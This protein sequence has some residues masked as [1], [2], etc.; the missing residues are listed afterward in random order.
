MSDIIKLISDINALL[1]KEVKTIADSIQT[2]NSKKAYLQKITIKSELFSERIPFPVNQKTVVPNKCKKPGIYVFVIAP[3][4]GKPIPIDESFNDTPDAPKLIKQN[5]YDPKTFTYHDLK[6]GQ[7]LY[8]GKAEDDLQKRVNEHIYGPQYDSTS[9]LKLSSK[10]RKKLLNQLVCVCFLLRDDLT[11]FV[12]IIL[13]SI[14]SR[15]H[16][17]LK[18]RVGSKRS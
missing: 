15:L 4:A 12:K 10:E 8:L 17:I 3:K 1:N 11:S 7:I 5:Y 6:N 9:A 2:Q 18:P 16:D 14:E 13:P